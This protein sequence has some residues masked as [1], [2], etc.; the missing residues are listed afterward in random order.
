MHHF[1][2]NNNTSRKFQ[3]FCQHP[4]YNGETLTTA[5]IYLDR[6]RNISPLPAPWALYSIYKYLYT[7]YTDIR[8]QEKCITIICKE[9]TKQ[10]NMLR[11]M[12]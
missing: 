4:V 10:H 12:V 9:N 5:V 6:H 11:C 7:L 1:I 3:Y 8:L 2:R